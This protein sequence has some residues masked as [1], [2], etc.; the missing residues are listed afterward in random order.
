[1]IDGL[2][3]HRGEDADITKTQVEKKNNYETGCQLKQ[4]HSQFSRGTLIL[5]GAEG[6]QEGRGWEGGKRKPPHP[7]LTQERMELLI[8]PY[9]VGTHGS[10]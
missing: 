10:P 2:C 7:T 6:G 3:A 8:N 9:V 1:M 4:N 5:Q